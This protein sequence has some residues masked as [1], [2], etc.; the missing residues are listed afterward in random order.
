MINEVINLPQ[1]Q[2]D[3]IFVEDNLEKF[4][5][6]NKD[7]FESNKKFNLRFQVITKILFKIYYK[8]KKER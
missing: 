3:E 8:L 2:K 7:F 5:K 6:D 1:E 4:N